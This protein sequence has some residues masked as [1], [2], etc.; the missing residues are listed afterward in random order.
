MANNEH[1][2]QPSVIKALTQHANEI[3]A[4]SYSNVDQIFKLTDQTKNSPEL[5]E[6]A[7]TFGMMT[8]K[9]EAREYALENTI[10]ELKKKNVQIELLNSQRSLLSIVFVS[11]VLLITLYIFVLGII[12]DQTFSNQFIAKFVTD[13]PVIEVISLAAVLIVV[14]TS[15]LRLIDFG[16]TF[17]GWKRSVIESLI[18]SGTLI[19]LLVLIKHLCN[20]YLPGLFRE[21]RLFDFSYFGFT[22][23]TYLV[24]APL[25]EFICRGAV[26]GTLEKILDI[27]YRGFFAILV[28]TFLFGAVHMM[29]SLNLAVASFI[30]G[31][32]WGWMYHRQKNLIGV[33]LSHFLIG[34]ISGLMGYWTL[35]E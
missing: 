2:I 33:S 35:L 24:V 15:N 7:E 28:T 19:L 9:I 18:V 1:T 25:Q 26:Q 30:T 31:W 4:G 6:L 3:V 27:R 14:L 34:N 22:Y 11:I 10:E 32:L 17:T 16:L 13:Y 23:V 29:S 5:A 8:V 21:T 20:R 12:H